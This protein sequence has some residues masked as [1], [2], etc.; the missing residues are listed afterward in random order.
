M[1]LRVP[2]EVVVAKV[3]IAACNVERNQPRLLVKPA[4]NANNAA[5]EVAK[6][7]DVVMSHCLSSGS[8]LTTPLKFEFVI[9]LPS[10]LEPHVE[11]TLTVLL[12]LATPIL[13]AKSRKNLKQAVRGCRLYS[14]LRLKSVISWTHATQSKG[15]IVFKKSLEILIIKI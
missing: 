4:R 13:L 15:L 12:E 11:A 6:P 10:V 2:E 14:L 7:F 3:V 8:V 9:A 5:K 1:R